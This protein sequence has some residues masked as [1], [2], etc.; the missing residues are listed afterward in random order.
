MII[1]HFQILIRFDA[2]C[3]ASLAILSVV[4]QIQIHT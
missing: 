2:Y 4:L 3:S 1:L